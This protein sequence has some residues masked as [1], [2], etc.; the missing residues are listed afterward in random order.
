MKRSILAILFC[1]SILIGCDNDKSSSSSSSALNDELSG[2]W[3]SACIPRSAST[4][5]TMTFTFSGGN[6]QIRS[7]LSSG[8]TCSGTLFVTETHSGT[9]SIGGASS[10]SGAKVLNYNLTGAAITVVHATAVASWNSGAFCGFNNWAVNVPKSVSLPAP[11]NCLYTP[12]DPSGPTI[13]SVQNGKLY[14]G[15]SND[16]ALDMGMPF[17]R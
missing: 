10:V 2:S 13:F 9:Y 4:S 11:T 7:D 12:V 1:S 3:K 6:V 17:S 15:N 5:V 14:L 16:T 8:A